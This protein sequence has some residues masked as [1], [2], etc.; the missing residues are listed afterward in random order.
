MKVPE[1][2]AIDG[3]ASSG[4][5]TVGNLVATRLGFLFFDTGIMYRAATLAA[6]GELGS[7]EKAREVVRIAENVD[8]EIKPPSIQDKRLMDVVVNGK[9]VTWDVRSPEVDSNVSVVSA[10]KGVRDAMTGQQRKI[11]LR[12]KVVMVGRD[13]G[14]VV[15][16]EAGLKIFLDASVEER[17]QRR[18]TE[19][20]ARG[21]EA[22][23]YQILE[24]MKRRD[25]IDTSRII[26]PLKPADDAIILCTDGMSIEQVVDAIIFLAA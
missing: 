15:L 4:K 22:S 16:P 2:I 19:L 25:A 14:T 23:L 6:L 3:P 8:I 1:I 10:Y 18:F 26:A 24:D 20:S 5:S 21:T 12:G 9:D 7:V 17:A 13:I 11:G